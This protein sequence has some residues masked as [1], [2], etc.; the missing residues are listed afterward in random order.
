DMLK[1]FTD[2]N[3]TLGAVLDDQ[4]DATNAIIAVA[5]ERKF[6]V[7]FSTVIYEQPDL[8]DAGIWAFKQK[9]VATLRAGTEG[10]EVDSRLDFGNHDS[11]IVKKFASCFFGTDLAPRL[12]A[13]RIDTLIITGCTTSGC[14]R[15]TAVDA[16]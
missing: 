6:P 11:L 8:E 9:G 12:E 5:H 1:A 14:V 7:I 2:P 4:I 10:V 3:M 13:Q 16:C 15:A